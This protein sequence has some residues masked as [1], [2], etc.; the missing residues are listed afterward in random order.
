MLS[1]LFV[2][3]LTGCGSDDEKDAQSLSITIDGVKADLPFASA[4][5]LIDNGART[6]NITAMKSQTNFMSIAVSDWDFNNPPE[7]ALIVKKYYAS[8]LSIPVGQCED[9]G[10][11]THCPIGIVTYFVNSD[12]YS[13]PYLD[14]EHEGYVNITKCDGKKVSGSFKTSIGNGNGEKAVEGTFENLPYVSN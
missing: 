9:V 14:E 3:F 2:V 11:E 6:L 7:K 12:L 4:V 1:V 8:I 5:L 13:S 10:T